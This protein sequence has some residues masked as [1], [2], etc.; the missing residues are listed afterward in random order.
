MTANNDWGNST[1]L[2]YF[3]YLWHLF[4]FFRVSLIVSLSKV[5]VIVYFHF[6]FGLTLF[7]ILY[8]LALWAALVHWCLINKLS[9]FQ[10][11]WV[12]HIGLLW[13]F[14]FVLIIKMYTKTSE[15]F[16]WRYWTV[17]SYWHLQSE[18]HH[19]PSCTE[20]FLFWEVSWFCFD[21]ATHKINYI[22][23]TK[24]Y[25]TYETYLL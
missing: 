5:L 20:V 4:H 1:L 13:I 21:I 18:I 6:C 15:K 19:S 24:D 25:F 22:Q 23:A 17:F 8:C 2:L 14:I 12:G 16:G 3:F 11:V 7:L 9:L 10:L